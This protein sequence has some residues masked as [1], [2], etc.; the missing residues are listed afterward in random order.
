VGT[1]VAIKTGPG[2]PKAALVVCNSSVKHA[3]TGSEY[4]ERVAQC[5]KAT[6]V[7]AAAH[8]KVSQLRDVTTGMLEGC[9]SSMDDETCVSSN[10]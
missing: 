7:L 10:L 4:P 9:R 3:L 8:P 5:E 2:V 6:A 1:A